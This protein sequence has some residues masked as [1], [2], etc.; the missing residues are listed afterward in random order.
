[1]KITVLVDN[2]TLIEKYFY[3]EPGLSFLVEDDGKKIL[4]DVGYSD[5]FLKNA[6]KMNIS[7]LDLD[8]VVLSHG[9]LDHTWGLDPLIKHFT[10][11]AL[12]KIPFKRPTLVTHPLTFKSKKIKPRMEIGSLLTEEKLSLHFEMLM[13]DKPYRLTPNLVYLGEIEHT[14][15]FEALKSMGKV[16]LETGE[17]DDFLTEDSAL[18]YQSPEGLVVITGCSHAGICN[19]TEHARKTCGEKRVVDIIGGFH[20]LNPPK[21]VL[22][23]TLEYMKQLNPAEIHAC[24]CT[25]LQSKIA[26]AQAAPLKEV[27]VGMRFQ[28]N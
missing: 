16:I 21:R 10:E 2:N 9:H 1:M 17:E 18:A 27:G 20:L 12:E 26:L 3:G 4:F 22:E 24:H 19:I 7:L 25:D 15:D 28:Y 13:T 8:F 23:G 14:N 5:A 6:A 11:A